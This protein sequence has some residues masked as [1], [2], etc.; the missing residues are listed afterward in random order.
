MTY[1]FSFPQ[2]PHM[3]SSSSVESVS[4]TSPQWLDFENINSGFVNYDMA[5]DYNFVNANSMGD[6]VGASHFM[7]MRN[8]D[9]PIN[10][11]NTNIPRPDNNNDH[12]HKDRT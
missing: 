5:E 2:Q 3:F 8:G 4:S 1:D 10:N 12:D 6:A 11:E 9:M 7:S